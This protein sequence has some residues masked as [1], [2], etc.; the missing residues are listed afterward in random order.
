MNALELLSEVRRLGVRLWVDDGRLAYS[1]PNGVMASELRQELAGQRDEL[2]RLL[3]RPDKSSA[4]AIPAPDRMQRG[5]PSALSF[6]QERLWFLCQL[7]PEASPNLQTNLRWPGPLNV[8]ALTRSLSEIV[9][10]HE[11]LRTTFEAVDGRPRQVIH[12]AEPVDV[13][14]VD[15]R[16]SSTGTHEAEAQRLAAEE[17][18]RAFDL[19]EGPLFRAMLVR[20]AD[21]DHVLVLTMH[22]IVSDGWSLGVLFRELAVLYDCRCNTPTMPSG[23]AIGCRVRLSRSCWATGGTSL[24]ERRRYWSCRRTGHAPRC[25][26]S[27]ARRRALR[28]RPG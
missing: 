22:H 21:D 1:A 7:A 18:L 2:I 13:R 3:A 20:L 10:R 9:R 11:T 17:G 8:Q 25:R 12:A 28:C 14:L 27:G 5:A 23:S 26:A 16:A 6:A 15:V 19:A 4:Q 24:W